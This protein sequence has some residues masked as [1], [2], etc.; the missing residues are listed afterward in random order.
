MALIKN[1]DTSLYRIPLPVSLS[2][3]THGTI[4]GFEP[5]ICRMRDADGAEGVG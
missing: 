4:R 5:V 1:I 2:D 3:S